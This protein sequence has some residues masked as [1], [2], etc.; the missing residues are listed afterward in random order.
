MQRYI[1]MRLL[2]SGLAL[3]ILSLVIFVLARATGDPL[4]LILPMQA[5]T[6]DYA[7]ARQVLGL[8]KPLPHQYW[9]FLSHAVRGD[10]GMSIRARR[11]VRELIVE[12]LPNSIKLAGFALLCSVLVAFPLG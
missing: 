12:R 1:A 4:H 9:L 6:E 7:N 8:D 3:V 11:P 10:F 5:T 2:Q